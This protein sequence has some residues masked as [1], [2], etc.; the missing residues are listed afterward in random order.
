MT[1]VHLGKTRKQTLTA[2]DGTTIPPGSVTLTSSSPATCAAT[3]NPVTNEVSL[4]GHILGTATITYAS[5]GYAS[6]TDL[7]TVIPAPGI[8]VTDGAEI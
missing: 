2:T 8:I 7:V 1:T 6:A 3:V 4:D 5:P